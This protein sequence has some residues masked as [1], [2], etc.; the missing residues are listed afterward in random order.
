LTG[1]HERVVGLFVLESVKGGDAT[2]QRR[3]RLACG[4]E[5]HA[6]REHEGDIYD[7]RV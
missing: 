2:P 6:E 1:P 4:V 5:A 3:L 7:G